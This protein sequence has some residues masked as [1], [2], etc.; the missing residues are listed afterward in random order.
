MPT[1]RMVNG[2]DRCQGRVEVFH[3]N[4][5]GTVCD[6][7]WDLQDA[8]VVCRQLG[9]GPATSAISQ[10]YFG[11]GSDPI[12]L[13]DVDCKG[14]ELDLST[15]SHLGWGMHNCNHYEDAGVICT[16]KG[17]DSKE[18]CAFTYQWV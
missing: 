6:D 3:I 10:A 13:D 16:G 12:L 14:S 11:L 17:F 2:N 1:I 18:L 7:S 15:C 8:Q 5:W 9:C 4:Q